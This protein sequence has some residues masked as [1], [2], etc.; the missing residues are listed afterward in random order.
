MD[1]KRN[2]N[3]DY[4]RKIA[5][6]IKKQIEEFNP[7]V[8]ITSDDNA[9]KYVILPYFRNSKI[10]IIFC[11]V[12]GTIKKYER[13]PINITGMEEVQPVVEMIKTLKPYS[14]KEK[15]AYLKGDSFS[16]INEVEFFEKSI[17]KK[18]DARFVKTVEEW[19]KNFKDLQNSAGIL[20]IGNG[21]AIKG[22]TKYE[23]E[24]EVFVKEHIK[25]PIATWDYSVMNLSVLGYTTKAEEQ[26]EWVANTAL[27]VLKGENINN[28]PIVINK[29]ANIYINTTLAKKLNIVFP[30][31]LIDYA[32]IIK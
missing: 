26:G 15:V 7:D 28:I 21:G 22:W 11:G 17:N 12:N 32:E 14:K 24:F 5:F 30:Y 10:P 6:K 3:E 31:D 16:S 1:S 4:K 29:K 20:L 2:N 25:I 27:R 19:K 8:I 13:L 23:K 18:I 9:I